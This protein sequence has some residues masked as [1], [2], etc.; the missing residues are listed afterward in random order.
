MF[1]WIFFF[2]INYGF[3]AEINLSINFEKAAA[4]V[5]KEFLSLT[6]DASYFYYKALT[7]EFKSDILIAL[8][9]GLSAEGDLYL[10]FGG[11]RADFINVSINDIYYNKEKLKVLISFAKETEW[12]LIFGLNVL[13]RYPD[14]SWNFYN[15]TEVLKYMAAINYEIKFELSNE[16][17][18]FPVLFNYTLKPPQ[19]AKDFKTLRGILNDVFKPRYVQLLGP[20]VGSITRLGFFESFLKSIENNVLDAIT[21]HHYYP[22][23]DNISPVNFTSV[24]Y[25]D[26]FLEYGLKA[27][28]II[29][30]SVGSRFK[31]PNIWI[32]ETSSTTFGGVKGTG[33]SF[34]AGFLWLDKLG[35]AAQMGIKVVLRQSFKGGN[36]SLIN[37]E[38]KPTPDY[39]SSLLYKRLVGQIVLNLTGYLKFGRKVR[40][41]AHC[42]SVKQRL[43]KSGSVVLI[44]IN[45]NNKENA[46][47]N[48]TNKLNSDNHYVDQYLLQPANGNIGDG[49]VTLN[50]II[51]EMLNKTKLPFLKPIQTKLPLIIPP[52]SYGFFVLI[53]SNAKVCIS[54]PLEN[55]VA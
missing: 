28:S 45:V 39:W 15:V 54:K 50:G 2:A 34:A 18:N 48:V 25:L 37:Q 7:N 9:K 46:T 10:R 23:S 24:D 42:A 32:G 52:L 12:K 29:K 11:T 31:A 20:D 5:E 44:A 1:Y 8:G 22:R 16:F 36:Y 21:F 35:L 26:T 27:I 17:D 47:I 53:D 33:D 13:N 14:G 38:F 55:N 51:L 4:E 40:V 49:N 43:Y 41:Y 19:L 30:K 6:I 3:T